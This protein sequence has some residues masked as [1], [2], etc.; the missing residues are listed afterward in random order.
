MPSARPDR[1]PMASALLPSPSDHGVSLL[2]QCGQS[3]HMCSPRATHDVLKDSCSS[4]FKHCVPRIK[5]P[6]CSK[7]AKSSPRRCSSKCRSTRCFITWFLRLTLRVNQTGLNC[8]TT[9]RSHT[10]LYYIF[11]ELLL[12]LR[13]KKRR[14]SERGGGILVYTLLFSLLSKETNFCTTKNSDVQRT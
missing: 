13:E 2:E 10:V 9:C 12:L 6:L 1:P 14:K 4:L 5:E 7:R 11:L 3:A 8:A